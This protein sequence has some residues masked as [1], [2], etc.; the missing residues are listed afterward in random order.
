ML[1]LVCRWRLYLGVKNGELAEVKQAVSS[2]SQLAMER[3]QGS[4]RMPSSQPESR[5]GPRCG[6]ND[7]ADARLLFPTLPFLIG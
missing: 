3:E 6:G 2:A 5:S 1:A 7:F 4:P